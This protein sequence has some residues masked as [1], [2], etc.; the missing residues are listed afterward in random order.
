MPM[1]VPVPVLERESECESEC[2]NQSPESPASLSTAAFTTSPTPA[3]PNQTSPDT[4]PDREDQGRLK[5]SRPG[6]PK[7]CPPRLR[8]A[9]L[10]SGFGALLL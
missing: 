6:P 10:H 9:S 4:T 7:T 5:K 8:L 2:W 3:K 1:P